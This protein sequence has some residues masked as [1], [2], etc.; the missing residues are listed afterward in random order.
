ME[1]P[2]PSPLPPL[3]VTT[4]SFYRRSSTPIFSTRQKEDLELEGHMTYESLWIL[5]NLEEKKFQNYHAV[6]KEF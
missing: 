1:A 5:S 2:I 4:I 6:I 3:S